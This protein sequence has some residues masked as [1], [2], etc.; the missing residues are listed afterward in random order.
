MLWSERR[1]CSD[2]NRFLRVAVGTAVGALLT[3]GVVRAIV[4]LG[5]AM[6]EVPA[7]DQPFH[8]EGASVH[9]AWCVEHGLPLYP[10]GA[11]PSYV[12]NYMGPC[13]FWIVGAIGRLLDADISTLHVIGRTVTFLCG[14]GPAIVAAVYLYRRHGRM[15]SLV[16]L[17][18]GLGSGPMIGY[19]L[20]T[21]PDMMADLL[22]VTGFFA[23]CASDRRW[24]PVAAVLLA[25]S[26]LT[27][28]TAGVWLLAAVVV[29]LVREGGWRR[30]LA[31][32]GA[33]GAM[34]LTI[35]FLLA[36]FGEP[37]ILSSLLGQ[38]AVAFDPQQ[39]IGILLLL[40]KRSP[41]IILFA[42]IG[43][44]LWMSQQYRDRTL[45]VLTAVL[46]AVAAIACA[47]RGSDL[48][49]FVP[50]RIVEALAA[51]TLC[52][53]A[54]RSESH[55]FGWAALVLAGVLASVPSTLFAIET[56]RAVV[57]RRDR[58]DSEAGQAERRQFERLV[59][60]AQDSDVRL[61][62]DSDRLA[63]YQGLQ[64]TLLDA[65]LFRL[66]VDSGRLD[67]RELIDR[68]RSRWFEYV[69][70]S[71]DASGVYHDVFFYRLPAEVASAIQANY[72]LQAEEAGLL[73]YLPRSTPAQV[74]G[75]I[76]RW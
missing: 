62:T 28:Q 44:G 10:E 69:V 21:R 17:V 45:L 46:V 2:S 68:L 27:K 43:C 42:L 5:Y 58:L 16:G 9:F 6:L 38:G 67:P 59:R 12:V 4:Y 60:L 55:R 14:L 15:A 23:A 29:W 39:Q 35:V 20:M 37:H 75:Q 11:G 56:V 54:L 76:D 33:S 47:K 25:L 8:L 50:L 61:L 66:R 51:G 49:Y 57:Q 3:I 22:G 26:C 53:A 63:V 19:G 64:A 1:R 41:E 13:Y 72:T 40:L 74:D 31:L 32:G 18:F 71:A 7:P 70:L 34:V 65:Y 73:V 24:L 52:A 30:A 36:T 48:N